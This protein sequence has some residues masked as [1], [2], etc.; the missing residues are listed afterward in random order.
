MSITGLLPK[1]HTLDLRFL[2]Q[3]TK[4]RLFRAGG[5]DGVG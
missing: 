3:E 5:K 1:S 4:H 2:A